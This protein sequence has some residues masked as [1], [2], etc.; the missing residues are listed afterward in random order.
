MSDFGKNEYKLIHYRDFA[1][2]INPYAGNTYSIGTSG[3]PY[4]SIHAVSG[5]FNKVIAEG[6]HL[7]LIPGS[8]QRIRFFGVTDQGTSLYDA[9]D[10]TQYLTIL[11]NASNQLQLFTNTSVTNLF[12]IS[13]TAAP[14]RI[15]SVTDNISIEARG[16][17]RQVLVSGHLSPREATEV[18]D[19]GHV[20]KK[21]RTM[22]AASGVFDAVSGKLIRST[23]LIEGGTGPYAILGTDDFINGD[24]SSEAFVATLPDATALSGQSFTIK[25]TDTSVNVITVSGTQT[26]D[27]DATFDLLAQDEVIEVL[28]DGT[29]WWII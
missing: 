10:G 20:G 29:E 13:A 23:R 11:R 16:G 15:W 21:W 4:S 27:S 17:E 24:A 6:T 12:A 19:I 14:I 8:G 3:L 26:I 25:K 1:G 5:Y 28:S 22:Y 9:Y 18:F 7:D 2:N